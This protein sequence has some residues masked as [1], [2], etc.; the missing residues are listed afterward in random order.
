L[1][2][3]GS[4]ADICDA[5]L[6]RDGA[7]ARSGVIEAR[8][9]GPAMDVFIMQ[10]LVDMQYVFVEKAFSTTYVYISMGS[11]VAFLVLN[12]AVVVLAGGFFIGKS[13]KI[14][15]LRFHDKVA[16]GEHKK[17]WLWGTVGL[18]WCRRRPGGAGICA[19]VGN[20]A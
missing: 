12:I 17:F 11:V 15:R 14:L 19:R 10:L 1:T 9:V 16:L 8:L 3:D 4:T 18:M 2:G 20:S 5:A 7:T 13:Q 6:S